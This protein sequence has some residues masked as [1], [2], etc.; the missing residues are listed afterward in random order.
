MALL[1]NIFPEEGQKAGDEDLRAR[2]ALLEQKLQQIEL[3]LTQMEQQSSRPRPRSRKDK[4][5][6]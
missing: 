4:D 3:R 5:A 6:E 1:S 2:L